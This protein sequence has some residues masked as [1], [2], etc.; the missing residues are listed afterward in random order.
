[1]RSP[2]LLVLI[3]L[4]A[5]LP[6]GD[7]TAQTPTATLTT[8]YNFTGSAGDA[9]NPSGPLAVGEDGALFGT[10]GGDAGFG[11]A[12]ELKPPSAT[13]GAWTAKTLHEFSG[14]HGGYDPSGGVVIGRNGDLF[15]TA[16]LS[17]GGDGGDD[18]GNVFQLVQQGS[19]G[20]PATGTQWK[21]KLVF[22][23]FN[24][25]N[26][27]QPNAGVVI[28]RDGAIY[29]TTAM[30]G[31]LLECLGSGCGTV[32]RMTPPEPSGGAWTQEVLFAFN[33]QDGSVP[34]ALALGRFGELYGSTV[35][36][37][38][39]SAGTVF[40]LKPPD[41]PN[42][43]WTYSALYNF[44]NTNS[45]GWSPVGGVVIGPNGTLYGVT[46]NGGANGLGTV[47]ELKRPASPAAQWSETVIY[48]FGGSDGADPEAGL[49]VGPGPGWHFALYGTTWFGGTGP[50]AAT[51]APPGCGTV[52]VLAQAAEG[53]PWTENVLH[54]F[55]DTDGAKPDGALVFD[56]ATTGCLELY[57]T[58]L[59]G[60]NSGCSSYLG[61]GC[62]TV[63][64][65]TLLDR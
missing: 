55:T 31:S 61:S 50:C 32:F 8:I 29:G 48:S 26:G 6:V 5:S 4:T 53:E 57:G 37:G 11:T 60:G 21:E 25:R 33:G 49:V 2:K 52:F 64:K 12:F 56:P 45:D 16:A 30:G 41:H 65:L 42:G 28:G 27:C 39:A 3:T 7:C 13:G 14:F 43:A 47:F 9:A 24:V 54:S 58:T 20:S 36:G 59:E 10:A 1:M 22:D 35:F 62:G 63:F 51:G 17:G 46:Q 15:G 23:K 18:C 34:S 40:Q 44:T 38:A 19:S